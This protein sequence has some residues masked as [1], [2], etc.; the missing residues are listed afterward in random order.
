M[1]YYVITSAEY[2]NHTSASNQPPAWSLDNSKCI[3]EVDDSYTIANNLQEFSTS[4]ACNSWRWN[5][6]TQE[7][8]NWASDAYWNGTDLDDF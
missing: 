1:K 7:W 4:T 3:L 6:S 5:T 2:T 8:K